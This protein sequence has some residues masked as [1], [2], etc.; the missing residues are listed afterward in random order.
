M[1]SVAGSAI[2]IVDG[3]ITIDAELLATKLGL[4]AALLES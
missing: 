4:S 2:S 1:S 3:V